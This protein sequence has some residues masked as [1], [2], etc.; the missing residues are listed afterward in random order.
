MSIIETEHPIITAQRVQAAT[1]MDF[2][3]SAFGAH[4]L[5]M[6]GAMGGAD[7]RA[8]GVALSAYEN[9][10]GT[11]NVHMWFDGEASE[12]TAKVAA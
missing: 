3:P 12:A 8:K 6:L 11:G 1:R 4:Y 9:A 2:L 7:C 10:R 5:Q